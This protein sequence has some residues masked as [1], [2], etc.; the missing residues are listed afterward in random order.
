[1]ARSIVAP[2]CLVG[3]VIEVST[4]LESSYGLIGNT[5]EIGKSYLIEIAEVLSVIARMIGVVRFIRIYN[6]PSRIR[7]AGKEFSRT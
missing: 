3:H 5:D 4:H 6:H 1:M 2:N 7:I